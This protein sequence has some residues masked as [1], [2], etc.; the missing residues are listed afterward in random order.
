M[1]KLVKELEA[2][3][4]LKDT[5]T[6]GDIVIIGG[7][8]PDILMYAL[9]TDIVRDESRKDEWWQVSMSLL[10]IP[11]QKII[12]TLRTPQFTGQEIF[13]MGGAGRFIKALDMQGTPGMDIRQINKV[14][15]QQ[16]K[17]SAKKGG[18]LRRIK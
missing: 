1:E 15:G 17:D 4:P 13:T 5:T 2:Q 6:I 12:W 16:K 8:D 18:G 11:L 7:Q 9:V 10:T 3:L 14:G